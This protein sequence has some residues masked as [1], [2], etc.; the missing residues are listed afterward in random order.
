MCAKVDGLREL[1]VTKLM[2]LLTKDNI[3]EILVLAHQIEHTGLSEAC[4]EFATCKKNRFSYRFCL[5]FLMP[6]NAVGLMLEEA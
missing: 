5:L 4:V 2:S 1:C 3:A 6:Q